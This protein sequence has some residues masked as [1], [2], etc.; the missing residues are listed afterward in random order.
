MTY[1]GDGSTY[2]TSGD[3]VARN[4]N[5]FGILELT[6]PSGDPV[7]T[8]EQLTTAAIHRLASHEPVPER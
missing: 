1:S 8:V 4:G 5:Q 7:T 6:S 3:A 2:P